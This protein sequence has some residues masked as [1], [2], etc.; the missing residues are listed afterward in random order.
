MLL[1]K[2]LGQE[3]ENEQEKLQG[4]ALLIKTRCESEP[5]TFVASGNSDAKRGTAGVD[6]PCLGGD[7]LCTVLLAAYDGV[8][9]GSKDVSGLEKSCVISALSSLLAVSHSA[10]HTAL[11]GW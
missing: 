6:A 2:S 11:Q 8:Q 5:V 9:L 3:S 4:E 10:K 7:G 1:D